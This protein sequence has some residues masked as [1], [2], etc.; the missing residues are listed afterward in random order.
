VRNY[1]ALNFC[2]I[3]YNNSSPSDPPTA[4]VWITGT[5]IDDLSSQ[6]VATVVEMG[7][8]SIV[9]VEDLGVWY[10]PLDKTNL[11]RI[12]NHAVI[13]FPLAGPIYAA[14]PPKENANSFQPMKNTPRKGWVD[15]AGVGRGVPGSDAPKTTGT[16]GGTLQITLRSYLLLLLNTWQTLGNVPQR[17]IEWLT[18]LISHYS[19]Y[20]P[21]QIYGFL[22]R[23]DFAGRT[24]KV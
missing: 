12:W 24:F 10:F 15:A 11:S 7:F 1:V 6:I 13:G 9:D 2:R 22:A 20:T 14:D 5:S 23:V 21:T 4:S 8:I 18:L 19:R 3:N 16:G 17:W